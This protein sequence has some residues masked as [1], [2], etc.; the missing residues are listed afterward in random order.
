MTES[1]LQSYV[2][3]KIAS[4]EFASTEEFVAAAI[5]VYRQIETDHEA[6]RRDVQERIAEA[7]SGKLKPLDMEAIKSTLIRELTEVRI[8]KG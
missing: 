8:P 4:G 1:D 5:R 7:D 6:L 2:A 3:G